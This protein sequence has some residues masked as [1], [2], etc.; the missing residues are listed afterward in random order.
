MYIQKTHILSNARGAYCQYGTCTYS[1]VIVESN[2]KV[3][4][5]AGIAQDYGHIVVENSFIRENRAK[6]TGGGLHLSRVT[7]AVISNSSIELNKAAEE[8]GGIRVVCTMDYPTSLNITQ[9]TIRQNS[10]EGPTIG[11]DGGEAYMSCGSAH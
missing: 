4:D 6:H 5:G 1:S 11:N 10:I 9:S 3:A 2:T 8:G 7:S